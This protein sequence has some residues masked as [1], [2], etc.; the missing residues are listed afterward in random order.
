MQEGVFEEM[1]AILAELRYYSK[2][3]EMQNTYANIYSS[4]GLS[5]FPIGNVD[6]MSVKDLTNII[7]KPWAA[8]GEGLH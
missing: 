7:H 5:N 6:S 2:F 3:A 4:I 8:L 1:N